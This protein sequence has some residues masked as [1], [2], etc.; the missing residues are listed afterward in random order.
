MSAMMM[1]K[2]KA[3]AELISKMRRLEAKSDPNEEKEI[4]SGEEDNESDIDDLKELEGNIS[5]DQE[6]DGMTDMQRFMRKGPNAARPGRRPIAVAVSIR[7]GKPEMP[8]IKS[9]KR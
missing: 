9:R 4:S 8:P 5:P 2:K 6:D 3:L 1:A 7:S